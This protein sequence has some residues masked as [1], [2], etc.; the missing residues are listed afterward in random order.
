ME[1]ELTAARLRELLVYEPATGRFFWR[2]RTGSQ[3]AG[4]QAGCI[5]AAGY[6]V[7]RVDGRLRYAHRLAWLYVHGKWPEGEID[8]HNNVPGDDRIDNLRLANHTENMW[9]MRR[10]RTN[11]SGFKGV[12]YHTQCGKWAAAIKVENRNVHLGLFLTREAARDAYRAE[13]ARLRG[14]FARFE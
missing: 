5:N 6:R 11:R 12:H 2:R 10:F 14:S 4:A 3:A 13:A 7:I 8:H 1:G 9:N